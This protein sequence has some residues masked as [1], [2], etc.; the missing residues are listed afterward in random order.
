[1]N[2]DNER[3]MLI[4]FVLSSI[5]LVAALYF[6]PKGQKNKEVQKEPAQSQQVESSVSSP[7]SPSAASGSSLIFAHQASSTNL[8]LGYGNQL[9]ISIDTYGGRITNI[10]I[11]GKWNRMGHPVNLLNPPIYYYPGDSVLGDTFEDGV[12]LTNRP[13]YSILSSTSNQAVMQAAAQFNPGTLTIT[14]TFTVTSNLYVPRKHN[15]FQFISG[16]FKA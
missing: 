14:K 8:T 16:P 6:M 7:A 3:R 2:K 13:V 15:P 4:A 11:N 12:S 10:S 1:M 5:L 9:N